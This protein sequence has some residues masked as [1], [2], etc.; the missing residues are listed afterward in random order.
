MTEFNQDDHK[1]D[2]RV[3]NLEE[4]KMEKE[5]YGQTELVRSAP[6]QHLS[7]HLAPGLQPCSFIHLCFY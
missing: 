4:D 3:K 1:Q 6:L 5:K 2:I 7:S